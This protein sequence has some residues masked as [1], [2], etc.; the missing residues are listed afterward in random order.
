MVFTTT[1]CPDATAY[2][3]GVDPNKTESGNRGNSAYMAKASS[4]SDPDYANWN[5]Q[6]F[7]PAPIA[8]SSSS[9]VL[10]PPPGLPT[11]PVT[12]IP[13][14]VRVRAIQIKIRIWDKKSSQTRQLTIIQDL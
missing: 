11:Q 2:I 3:Y 9:A 5:G 6:H 12:N 7:R 8:A 13:L 10:A 1:T 4:P 14:R